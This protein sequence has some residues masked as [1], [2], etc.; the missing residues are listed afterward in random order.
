MEEKAA[1]IVSNGSE[2]GG[3]SGTG[4]TSVRQEV[5]ME[6]VVQEEEAEADGGGGGTGERL[7]GCNSRLLTVAIPT[8]YNNGNPGFCNGS[9][10]SLQFSVSFQ[11]YM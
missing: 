2:K 11:S 4:N 8:I 9:E 5:V 3:D 7:C 10:K 1:K 6:K